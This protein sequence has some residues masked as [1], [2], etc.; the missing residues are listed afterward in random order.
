[1]FVFP[2]VVG[3]WACK[4]RVAPANSTMQASVFKFIFSFKFLANEDRDSR[5]Y[6]NFI[7]LHLAK[8]GVFLDFR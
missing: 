5:R 1:V 6:E 8:K 4:P 7:F 3:R 2:G